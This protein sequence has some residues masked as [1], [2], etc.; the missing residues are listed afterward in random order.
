MVEFP[1]VPKTDRD[2]KPVI[3]DGCTVL[4]PDP[5]YEWLIEQFTEF[6]NN[7]SDHALDATTQLINWASRNDKLPASGGLVTRK[8][9]EQVSMEG[10]DARIRDAFRKAASPKPMGTVEDRLVDFFAPERGK[11]LSWN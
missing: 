6:G 11:E 5:E 8:V 1:G 9:V 7:A 10:C 2:G 3:R 4:I